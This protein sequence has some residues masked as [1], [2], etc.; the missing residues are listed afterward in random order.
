MQLRKV[1]AGSKELPELVRLYES[2]FPANERWGL[3][4]VLED[5]TGI[6]ELLSFFE[7]ETFCGFSIML[8]YGSLSHI[9]YFAV[10][11][12]LRSRGCG[13][14][15]LRLIREHLPEQVIMVDIEREYPGADNNEQRR[16]RK[17]FYAR[18]GYK[19]AGAFYDWRGERYEILI[20]GGEITSAGYFRFWHDVDENSGLFDQ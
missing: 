13:T 5:K 18:S 4:A 14:E 2:A 7:G 3:N 20:L 11:G 15:M 10:D 12:N 19:E 9:I 16:R 17:T 8:H 6:S 1:T